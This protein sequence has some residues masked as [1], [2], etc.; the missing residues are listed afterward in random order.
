M[1]VVQ[2][3]FALRIF[4]SDVMIISAAVAH[5]AHARFRKMHARKRAV[6]NV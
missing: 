1:V 2:A 6:K 5:T 3:L 4:A